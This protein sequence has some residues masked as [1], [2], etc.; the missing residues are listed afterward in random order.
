VK[1]AVSGKGGVG[2]TTVAAYLARCRQALGRSVVAV[3]ADPDA[4][5]AGALGYR[6]EPITPL[7]EVKA[8]IEE[9]VGADGGYLRLNPMVADIP[10]RCGVVVG[11]VRVLVMG[12]IE[13]GGQ[14]CAC[15]PNVLLREVL[16]HLV[17]TAEE[18]VIVDLEAGI[19]HLG[20]GTAAGVDEMIVVVEPG[21]ASLETAGRIAKLAREIGIERVT[22]L[23]NKMADAEDVRFV[24]GALGDLPLLGRLPLDRE[25][26][27]QARRG[28]VVD[29]S[30]RLEMER[31]ALAL[32]GAEHGGR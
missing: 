16:R 10:A 6:G 32:D 23:A 31:I 5:L 4:N 24:E 30:F 1:I 12:T 7:A 20:R 22:A 25:V 8:L 9:R 11:G 17:L 21:W 28:G 18:D 2:K 19:E 3:D 13:R 14:G 29:G 27:R 26:E 15:A